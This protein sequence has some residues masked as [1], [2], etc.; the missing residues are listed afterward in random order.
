MQCG[1]SVRLEDGGESASQSIPLNSLFS[2]IVNGKTFEG[3]ATPFMPNDRD[4][5]RYITQEEFEENIT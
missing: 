5:V 3:Q 2:V 4:D 1:F